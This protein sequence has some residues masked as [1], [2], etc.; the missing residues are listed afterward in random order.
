MTYWIILFQVDP[1]PPGAP[2]PIKLKVKRADYEVAGQ[3]DNAT[4]KCS[5]GKF[6][7][8]GNKRKFSIEEETSIYLVADCRK[9]INEDYK[10]E[11]K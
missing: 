11:S 1:I 3:D 10:K 2:G 5:K 7:I 8:T 6:V 4:I 9:I